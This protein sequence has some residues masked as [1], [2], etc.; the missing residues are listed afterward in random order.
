[1]C[2]CF[3][4]K[5]RPV[6]LPVRRGPVGLAV[7]ADV[8]AGVGLWRRVDRPILRVERPPALGVAIDHPALD[9]VQL[10]ILDRLLGR[11]EIIGAPRQRTMVGAAS[12]TIMP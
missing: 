8:Y 9:V 7:Q 11:V 10:C 1:M 12:S 5:K 2:R 3:T 6:E 4:P